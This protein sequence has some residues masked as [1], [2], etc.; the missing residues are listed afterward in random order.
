MKLTF[1]AGTPQF[2]VEPVASPHFTQDP[3]GRAVDLAG[4]SG[5]KVV[6]TGFRG[7]VANYSGETSITSTGPLLLQVGKLGDFEGV[8]SF[9]AGTSKPACANV[10]AGGS[11]LTFQFIAAP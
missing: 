7:D 3:S 6:L 8:V 5:V 10:T 9:G 2:R 4:S 1:A 11:T